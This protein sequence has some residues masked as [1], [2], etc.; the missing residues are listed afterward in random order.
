LFQRCLA[1]TSEDLLSK[2]QNKIQPHLKTI[3]IYYHKTE[4][5]LDNIMNSV[6]ES[7]LKLLTLVCSP[8]AVKNTDQ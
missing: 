3:T 7:L 4:Q 2:S 5:K 8:L 1:H 6:V